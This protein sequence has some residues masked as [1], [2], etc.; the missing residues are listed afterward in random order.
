MALRPSVAMAFFMSQPAIGS[1]CPQRSPTDQSLAD[2]VGPY[3]PHRRASWV[4]QTSATPP[5][6]ASPTG[7]KIQYGSFLQCAV[8]T[9]GKSS[10]LIDFHVL[11]M[12]RL[13]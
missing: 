4:Y 12:S 13:L 9:F 6:S 7:V 3:G 5:Q 11:K 10:G 8:C 1:V 2:G